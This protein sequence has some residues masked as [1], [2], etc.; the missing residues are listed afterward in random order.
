[1]E[2]FKHPVHHSLQALWG[3]PGAEHGPDEGTLAWVQ[4]DSLIRTLTFRFRRIPSTGWTISGPDRGDIH[5]RA[6]RSDDPA[7]TE[8]G[9]LI[10]TAGVRK[11]IDNRT[12][13]SGR[14]GPAMPA[15]WPSHNRTSCEHSRG[16]RIWRGSG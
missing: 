8:S 2:A 14:R 13:A 1:M 12:L 9:S 3:L 15:A 10:L 16:T 7:G 5:L 4:F 6:G 11:R